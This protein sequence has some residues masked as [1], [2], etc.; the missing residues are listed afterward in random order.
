[1]YKL[2][3]NKWKKNSFN[4][5]I[6]QFDLSQN[7]DISL[8]SLL[9][10]LIL[11]YIL[12]S[13]VSIYYAKNANTLSNKYIFSKNFTSLTL[14]T[15]LI[16]TVVKSSLAL[17]LG[18]VG[19][20]SIVRFRAA[21]KEPE[22]LVY[23]FICIAIGLGCGAN[24]FLVTTI[25]TFF[26]LVALYFSNFFI[27]KKQ[28]LNSTK[29]TLNIFLNN[30]NEQLV[31]TITNILIKFCKTVNFNSYIL[32]NT[33]TN[34]SFELELNSIKSIELIKKEILKI[35]NNAEITITEKNSIEI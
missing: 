28:K 31:D 4:F 7:I 11:A 2:N 23:L 9:I 19:A 24:Q 6:G 33:G 5:D 27:S 3:L 20:L 30:N 35:S 8:S 13:L 26:I 34:I 15:T 29:V 14:I 21:I 12:S 16:I 25:G 22:E 18:L 32:N 17:S 10:S 1:M